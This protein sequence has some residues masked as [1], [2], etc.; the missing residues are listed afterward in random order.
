LLAGLALA[1]AEDLGAAGA[2][3][4]GLVVGAHPVPVDD[5][6][7]PT[8]GITPDLLGEVLGVAGATTRR[9]EGAVFT[10]RPSAEGLVRVALDALGAV[11]HRLLDPSVGGGAFV[12]AAVR[13]LVRD[14]VPV[15]DAFDS[16]Q[17]H[18]ADLLS[19]Q[20][21]AAALGLW[22]AEQTGEVRPDAAI[23]QVT[24]FLLPDDLGPGAPMDLVVGNPPFLS[25]L[26]RSTT[27]SAER[28]AALRARY[29]V[30]V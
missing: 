15:L 26:R 10:P 3:H 7:I 22:C 2:E 25:Q 30:A 11:P 6:P 16:V 1:R 23:H 18:D 14:G 9:H 21:A 5:L 24:D 29:G 4:L 27:R 12:L 20:V 8:D 28:L 19:V 13:T 17:G